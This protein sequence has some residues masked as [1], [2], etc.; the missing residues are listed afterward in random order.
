MDR[1]YQLAVE[2]CISN[3]RPEERDMSLRPIG[4]LVSTLG[5]F[6]ASEGPHVRKLR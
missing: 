6:L 4:S 2:A 3:S 1:S 5:K